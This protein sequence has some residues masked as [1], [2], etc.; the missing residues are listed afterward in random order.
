MADDLKKF[1][2]NAKDYPD[3][4]PIKIGEV[5]VPLGSLRAL[6]TTERTQLSDRLKAVE[7]QETDLKGRQAK[8]VELAQ[9]PRAAYDAAEEAR[10]TAGT[11]PPKV[12]DDPFADPWLAPVKTE[13]QK[14]DKELESLKADLK[15]AVDAVTN[16]ATIGVEDRWDS[17][18]KA[19]D[20]GKREKKPT[21]QELLDFATK[22]N[23]TDRHRLP[24]ITEAWNKMSEEDRRTEVAEKARQE[25]IEEGKRQAMAG[26]VPPPGASGPGMGTPTGKDGKTPAG[27]LP[28]LYKSA[29]D[30]PELRALLEQAETHGIM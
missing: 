15:K 18:F 17:Q 4:T 30:D 16:I 29:I 3:T 25:G 10:K 19:I 7:T 6:N 13:L 22:N 21:R 26:R 23:L 27:E 28:D 9:K 2:D 8:V 1:L 5:E 24:S 11:N 12:G 20:F 14:R